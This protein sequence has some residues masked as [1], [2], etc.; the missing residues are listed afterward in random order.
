LGRYRGL[1]EIPQAELLRLKAGEAVSIQG[2]LKVSLFE[3]SGERR[4]NLNVTANHV[5]GF[6]Q[7]RREKPKMPAVETG[8]PYRNPSPGCTAEKSR[9]R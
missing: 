9:V 2:A 1:H 8:R 5:M 3:K 7:P 6:Q 4:A